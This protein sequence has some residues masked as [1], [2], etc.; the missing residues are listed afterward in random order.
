MKKSIKGFT[1]TSQAIKGKERGLINYLNYLDNPNAAS[2]Q[3]TK[4]IDIY[5]DGNEFIKKSKLEALEVDIKNQRNGKGGRPSESL[6]I[7]FD[8]TLPKNTIRPT[9][10][11]WKKIGKDL[12][13]TIKDNIETRLQKNH[14]FMNV[15]DQANPHLN[16]LCSKFMNG[17]RCRKI[18]QKALLSKLKTQYNKSVLQHCDFDYRDYEPEEV[19]LSSKRKKAWQ[20]EKQNVDKAYIQFE[21]L[22]D[23]IND[24]N[25]KR[26]N[27]TAN[28]I[29][30]TL[31][32]LPSEKANDLI[33]QFSETEDQEINKMVQQIKDKTEKSDWELPAN[34]TIKFN[35]S[36]CGNKIK[37]KGLC[38]SCKPKTRS[39]Y[40]I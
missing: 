29:I 9:A 28:R 11:Q 26:Q 24:G 35:C 21:K 25:T 17:K 19:G 15:H 31:S 6:A 2:H 4:F 10:E 32:K 5:G 38:S 27:S 3:D 34:T 30:K 20:L 22:V 18:D 14:V 7:S 1:V 36:T 16:L 13:L 39:T 23:Y 12:A 33:I 8:F 37:Q 40:K